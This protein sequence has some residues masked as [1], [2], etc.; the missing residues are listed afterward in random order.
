MKIFAVFFSL[1]SIC[2][3]TILRQAFRRIL[4]SAN[5]SGDHG[6]T[7]PVADTIQKLINNH[8]VVVF[9]KT[10]CKIFDRE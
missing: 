6:S 4:M 7:G 10:Y 9:S 2:R 8:K 5:G 1:K 3:F